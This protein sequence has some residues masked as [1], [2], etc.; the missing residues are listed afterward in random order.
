MKAR[1]GGDTRLFNVE[2]SPAREE[3]W[4]ARKDGRLADADAPPAVDLREERPWY[5]VV[6]Q[7]QTGSCVGWAL[8]DSVMR[9]Q[10]VEAGRLAPRTRLSARFIWMA[11]KEY[12]AQRMLL[13]EWRPSTF[14]E[15]APTTAKDAL[16]V[17]R[18][19]G[20][21]TNR[22]L[23]WE[24]RLN[25]G[26]VDEFFERAAE[27]RIAAFHSLDADDFAERARRWRQ[28]IHQHGP[29][30]L[31]VSVDREFID[32]PDRI[33]RHRPRRRP[34][35]HACALAGYDEHGFIVR[36]SWGRRWGARGD[37]HVSPAW[38]E[39]AVEETYGVV[40]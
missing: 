9:W 14:L 27:F 16:E 37:A 3:D 1:A 36:N 13:D 2:S 38:L 10:L 33:V 6:D 26:P 21:V 35:L 8:A 22:T 25:R 28:W 4:D 5:R 23:P 12:R 31:V 15:E 7:G 34:F 18:R 30:L 32:G 40:V 29:V 39:A 19:Y 24:G 20:A 11:S 17:V